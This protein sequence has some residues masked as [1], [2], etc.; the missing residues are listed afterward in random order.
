MAHD[1]KSMLEREEGREHHAYPDPLTHGEP[2][3]CGIGCTG[4]DIG[5]DTVWTDEQI[6]ARY[7]ERADEATR[8]CEG[9]FPWFKALNDARQA[10]LVSMV[11][12]MGGQGVLD[13]QHALAAMRD[14]H[15]ATAAVEML[16]SKWARQ[17]PKR[18]QRAARQMETGEWQ[19]GLVM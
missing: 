18:A 13:F 2:Y 1:L 15:W 12:Q 6:D 3:T 4:S 16:D 8:F 9:H 7:Q 14:E 10:V 19:N 5:P 17:T 11:Y